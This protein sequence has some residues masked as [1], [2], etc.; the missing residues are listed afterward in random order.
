MDSLDLKLIRKKGGK[1]QRGAV[2]EF[3]HMLGLSDE[4]F[5]SSKFSKDYK[6]VMNSGEKVYSRHDMPYMKWL[7]AKLVEHKVK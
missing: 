1:F 6:S 5:K 2:H 4:Y 3:G 7:N